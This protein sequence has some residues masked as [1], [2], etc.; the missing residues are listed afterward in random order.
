MPPPITKMANELAT[1]KRPPKKLI[2]IVLFLVTRLQETPEPGKKEGTTKHQ[3]KIY[4][5]YTTF[6]DRRMGFPATKNTPEKHDETREN[7]LWKWMV[8][9]C[10]FQN[11]LKGGIYLP[12]DVTV[13]RGQ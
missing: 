2:F 5:K 12:D 11:V 1:K 3:N 9:K 4:K 7:K 6:K 8:V 10:R 13:V